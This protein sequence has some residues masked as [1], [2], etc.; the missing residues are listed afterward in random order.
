MRD[1]P[2]GEAGGPSPTPRYRSWYSG[3]EAKATHTPTGVWAIGRGERNVHECWLKALRLLRVAL[4]RKREYG[5]VHPQ[6]EVIRTYDLAG[7]GDV[8]QGVREGRRWIVK[9]MQGVLDYLD[10]K[11]GN[12]LAGEDGR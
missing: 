8:G 12:E 6:M 11:R 1:A 2:Y 3:S 10:G 9:G 5:Q 7:M 4:W